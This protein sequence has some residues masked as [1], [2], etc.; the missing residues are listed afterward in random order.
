MLKAVPLERYE[1]I[2]NSVVIW[3]RFRFVCFCQFKL[4]LL[5]TTTY[6]NCNHLWPFITLKST[7]KLKMH[8]S[9]LMWNFGLKINPP[10]REP[11]YGQS[12][13]ASNKVLIFL[14]VFNNWQGSNA[15][16]NV[17]NVFHGKQMFISM[18]KMFTYDTSVVCLCWSVCFCLYVHL[19]DW[20]FN[21]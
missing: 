6:N 2:S 9:V 8:F 21:N 4:I 19:F 10:K 13:I 18:G 14:T 3:S 16:T 5:S 15:P 11:N 1:K 20:V 7:P 17:S 12:Q